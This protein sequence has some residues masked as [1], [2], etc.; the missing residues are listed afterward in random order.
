MSSLS[1]GTTNVE[2]IFSSKGN[3]A[4]KR[5][6]SKN[7]IERSTRDVV[8]HVSMNLPIYADTKFF[9]EKDMNITW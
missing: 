1:S 4:S 9:I 2:N 6:A 5:D 8:E 7:T 3:M